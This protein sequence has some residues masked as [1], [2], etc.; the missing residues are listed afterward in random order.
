MWKPVTGSVLFLIGGWMLM[1]QPYGLGMWVD[2][3]NILKIAAEGLGPAVLVFSGLLLFWVASEE[4]KLVK[5]N[6]S[7]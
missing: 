2:F 6:K 1:P 5:M 4:H 7:K 3:W